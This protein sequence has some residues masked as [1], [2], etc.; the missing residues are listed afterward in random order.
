MK[1]KTGLATGGQ[2]QY[3]ETVCKKGEI[4]MEITLQTLLI[5]CP[6][7]FLAGLIDAIAGGGGLISLP[8]YF[9][10]GVPA[11]MAIATNKLS[12]SI[13]TLVAAFRFYRRRLIQPDAALMGVGC[14]LLGSAIGSNLS[15]MASENLIRIIM[16][17]LLP[18]V[19]RVWLPFFWLPMFA[20]SLLDV[21]FDYAW[22]S[23]SFKAC[24]I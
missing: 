22:F 9:F 7:V 1:Q 23:Q 20:V 19:R 6:L 8:A 21:L 12:S 15:L 17:P 2:N 14:A 13:G 5:V 3:N 10:A 16:I 4:K 24:S 11:H 18:F